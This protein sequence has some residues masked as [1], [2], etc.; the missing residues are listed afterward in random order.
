LL[1]RIQTTLL[2]QAP[3][4]HQPA[5]LHGFEMV[6]EETPPIFPVTR[7]QKSGR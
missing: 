4:S 6:S 3:A 5:T 7:A 2:G 1:A